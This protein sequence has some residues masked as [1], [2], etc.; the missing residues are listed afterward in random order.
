MIS[1][2]T[3]AGTE[4][5]KMALSE[6]AESMGLPRFHAA[7]TPMKVPRLKLTTVAMPIRPRVQI[8]ARPSSSVTG[9]GKYLT[10]RPR[11]PVNTLC[12]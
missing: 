6:M 9:R 2:T 4:L 7:T 10:D 8:S 12:R 3:T 11:S 1:D 5:E